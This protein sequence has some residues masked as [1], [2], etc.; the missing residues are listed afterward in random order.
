MNIKPF[1]DQ[2][3]VKPYESKQVIGSSS[4]CKYGEVIAIGDGVTEVKVGEH[5]GF[6]EW[7]MNKLEINNET[8][9]FV[10]QDP[11]WILGTIFMP[12]QL[13]S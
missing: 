11:R 2:I 13:P 4:L 1:F 5:I 10:R 6:I 12:E 3:L 7:G 9:Y 8:F